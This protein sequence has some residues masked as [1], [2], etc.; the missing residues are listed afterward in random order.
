[1]EEYKSYVVIKS[2]LNWLMHREGDYIE[3]NII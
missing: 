3:S 2:A 1:M